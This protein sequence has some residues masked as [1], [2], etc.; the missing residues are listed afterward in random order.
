M[1]LTISC[2]YF[3]NSMDIRLSNIRPK[4]LSLI[5]LRR[6]QLCPSASDLV[7]PW[8][9]IW[10]SIFECQFFTN[11][12]PQ[13]LF[14]LLWIKCELNLMDRTLFISLWLTQ[15]LWLNRYCSLSQITLWGL[16]VSQPLCVK[17]L[18]SLRIILFGVYFYK[19]E[20]NSCFLDGLLHVAWWKRLG[21]SESY[22]NK[23]LLLKL[24]FHMLAN[25]EAFRVC[26]LRNKYNVHGLIP[27]SIE[28]T[29]WWEVTEGVV[30]SVDDGRLINF[31]N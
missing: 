24:G 5:T 18:T 23:I 10:G 25:T 28:R 8:W 4:S 12:W 16:L 20:A 9:Q 14:N 17:R 21:S 3:I 27:E 1:G 2:Q 26:I 13:T 19:Y 31:W 6:R 7:F 30:W 29:N 15:L 11:V 22:Q